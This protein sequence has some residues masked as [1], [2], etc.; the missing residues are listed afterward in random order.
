MRIEYTKAAQKSLRAM[1]AATAQRIMAAVDG[2]AASGSGD[3]KK[4]RGRDEY[5]LRVG[6]WRV[7]FEKDRDILIV[8][9]ALG[10]RG[11]VYK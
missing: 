7:L 11:D 9:L 3:V 8:V 5:R 10:S 6:G 4:L 2:Y 1:P